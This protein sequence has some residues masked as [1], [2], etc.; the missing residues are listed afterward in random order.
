MTEAPA[1][2]VVV[3]VRNG[4]EVLERCLSA[5]AASR[6]DRER[7][8]LLVVDDGSTDDS[9]E[10]AHRYTPDVLRVA[11]GPRGPGAARNLGAREARG[12]ILVFVDAD[13][14]V[15]ADALTRFDALFRSHPDVGA[16]FGAYDE[17]PADPGFLSQYRNLYHRWVHLRGAGDAETF[18][19]GCGAVRRALFLDLGG[20]D[21]VR[22][23]RPQIEDIEL[24]YRITDAGWRIVL[25]PAIQGT[26]LKRWTLKGMI[27]TDLLDRGIPWMRLLLAQRRSRTLNVSGAERVRTGLMGMACLLV[28]WAVALGDGRPALAALGVLGLL[29]ASNLS[30]YRWF[31][32]RR[33]WGFALA[34]V[35]F[36]LL[37]YLLSGLSVVAAAG[38]PRPRATL[39]PGRSAP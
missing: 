32:R 12:R 7:W 38:L 34:V 27:R 24:G 31:A 4:G 11:D 14:C 16:A 19:A 39:A 21:T 20:F 37:F 5:L 22:Y 9:A 29:A 3:P 6:L 15:H 23:P 8:E 18:W 36:N 28:V 33:G 1:L 35:P 17:H 2:S 30:V 26:H 10:R 13:V 25:D